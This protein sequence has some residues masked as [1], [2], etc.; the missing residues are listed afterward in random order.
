MAHFVVFVYNF[1]RIIILLPQHLMEH[2]Y[3]V[4]NVHTSHHY[5]NQMLT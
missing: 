1:L 4:I 2:E 5:F 3:Y